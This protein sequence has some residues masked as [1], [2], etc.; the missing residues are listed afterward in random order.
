VKAKNP[1]NAEGN[2]WHTLSIREVYDNPWIRVTHR[3]VINPAGKPGIY[4]LV[5]F[6]NLAIGVVPIDE[7]G[8]TWLVGQYRYT[9]DRYSWEIPEGGC[10]LGADPLEAAKRELKEE[11]GLSAVHWSCIVELFHTS[12]SVTDE[13]GMV[14]VARDLTYGEAEP[15]DTEQLQVR[16]L[17]LAE[18]IDMVMRGE[19]TDSLSMIALLKTHRLFGT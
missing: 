8:Y 17:P 13:A 1:L 5:H 2:P 16:R 19:I 10:P 15:E 12:N 9:I 11:T 14:F 6:K 4:G 18:A 7:E 3:E